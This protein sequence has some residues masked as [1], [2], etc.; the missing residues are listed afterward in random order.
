[1]SIAEQLDAVR[2]RV[3]A[4]V[5]RRSADVAMHSPVE[6]IAVSK[7][8]PLEAIYEAHDA[9]QRHFAENYAQEFRDKVRDCDARELHW[10]FIGHLQRNKVKYVL[11]QALL[12]TVDSLELLTALDERAL[13]EF[14][15]DARIPI[16]IEVN[17]GETQKSG[18]PPDALPGLLDAVSQSQRLRCEGLMIMAPFGPAE[19]A[20]PHFRAL[21]E[22]RDQLMLSPRAHVELRE[23]SMGMSSDFE[24]AIEEGAT[25]VR[26]GS[27]IFGARPG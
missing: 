14:E 7:R 4:A 16:L 9:G 13:R 3:Q 15:G 2:E 21:R 1:M 24:V 27:A 20:R 23:L 17:N 10:H 22:L 19:E 6:L 8:H 12:H 5:S 26:V 18:T 25:L 11:G